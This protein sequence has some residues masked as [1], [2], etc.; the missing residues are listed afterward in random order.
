M[1]TVKQPHTREYYLPAK[2]RSLSRAVITE[3]GRTVWLAG[4][5]ASDASADFDTQV[6]DVLASI[7]ETIKGAGGSGL[8]DLVT[9]TVFTH[10]GFGER[11]VEIRKEY[12]KDSYPASTLVGVAGFN[13]R[14]IMLE[15]QG[16]AVIGA[17]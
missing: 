11:F 6:R 8:A 13:R 16:V 3:G 4:R 10:V 5:I 14:G 17:K 12:F 7:D 2:E 1:S 15:V 9:M